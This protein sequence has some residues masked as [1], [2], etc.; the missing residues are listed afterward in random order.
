MCVC[1]LFLTRCSRT[2]TVLIVVAYLSNYLHFTNCS[3]LTRFAI[4][5][6]IFGRAQLGAYQSCDPFEVIEIIRFTK[7]GLC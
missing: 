2:V 4:W 6:F 3:Q 5:R 7:Y 1:M